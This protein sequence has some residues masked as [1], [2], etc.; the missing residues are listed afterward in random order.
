MRISDH[1]LNSFI[2]L[3]RQKYEVV[4]EREKAMELAS[5]YLRLIEV[6]ESNIVTRDKV[7][8]YGA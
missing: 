1:L 8:K 3:Y 6:V 5:R 2:E 7:N 4:L